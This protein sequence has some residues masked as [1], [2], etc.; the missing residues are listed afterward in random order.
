MDHIS[1]IGVF[2]SVAKHQSFSA[3]ARAL[4]M[5]GPALSKQVVN[6]EEQLGVRLF[7]RT[8]R[9]VQ[10]T[11]EGAI[12]AERARKAL[13]DISEAEALIQDHKAQPRGVL[14][15]SAP[16]SFGHR[17]LSAPIARFA[18]TYPEVRLNVDFDD[19]H[20]DVI[21][22]GYDVA[23]R[24]GALQDSSLIARKLAPCPL[25]LCAS[26]A[27]INRYG[28]PKNPQGLLHWPAIVY[29]KHGNQLLWHYAN[30]QGTR[31]SVSLS[32]AMHANNAELMREA[33]L[34][35]IGAALLPI[36]SVTDDLESGAL[37]ALLPDYR[38]EPVL[39]IAA[40]FPANRHLST[41]TRLFVD[42]L[43]KEA[44]RFSWVA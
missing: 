27:A 2:L 32:P 23:V 20:V 6:L 31:G 9:S 1:R 24:I 18:A 4:G 44:T 22:E 7:N 41:K 3:A 33:C 8:T 35:G 13:E 34:Q 21:D 14:R 16:M 11:E 37:H 42:M 39:H 19:R 28:R 12:Y 38:C 17:Y 25:I 29:S 15:V 10:L 26:P 5:T 30:T 43:S 40:L 36:F